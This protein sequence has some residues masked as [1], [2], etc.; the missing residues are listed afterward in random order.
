LT[1]K[2]PNTIDTSII[3]RIEPLLGSKYDGEF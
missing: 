3:L 2:N 1:R